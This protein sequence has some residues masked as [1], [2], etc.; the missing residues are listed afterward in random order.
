MRTREVSSGRPIIREETPPIHL[1]PF[2][3]MVLRYNDGEGAAQEGHDGIL[4][5]SGDPLRPLLG[6]GDEGE[7]ELAVDHRHF[8]PCHHADR[9]FDPNIV[10]LYV[11]SE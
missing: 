4:V 1:T 6:G 2:D 9:P 3:G 7:D 5:H 10:E 11:V 8:R